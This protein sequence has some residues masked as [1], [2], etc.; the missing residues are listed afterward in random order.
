MR[1]KLYWVL[2]FCLG[3]SFLSFCQD[4]S[5]LVLTEKIIEDEVNSSLELMQKG[6]L[7]SYKKGVDNVDQLEHAVEIAKNTKLKLI[8]YKSKSFLLF[9]NYDYETALSYIN[10]SIKILKNYPDNR[11]LGLNY[12]LLGVI[13]NTQELLK[14]RDNYFLKAER[15]LSKYESFEENID[16]NFNLAY[17]YKEYEDWNK[18]I[19]YSNQALSFIKLAEQT[20]S[21]SRY[22]NLFLAESYLKLNDLNRVKF[23]LDRVEKDPSFLPDQL[24]LMASYFKIKGYLFE[25]TNDFKNATAS[26]NISSD[27]YQKLSLS[28]SKE[29][30]ETLK[31]NHNLQ[32]KEKENYSIKKEIEY[33]EASA[34]YKNFIL[35]LSFFIILILFTLVFYQ[36][37]TSKFKTSTNL[38]LAKNNED[39]NEKNNEIKKVLEVKNK[40]LDTVT[41]ELRTPLNT[42]KGVSYLLENNIDTAKNEEYFKALS[43]SSNYL[44]NLVNNIIEYNLL[45]NND[46]ANL[47]NQPTNIFELVNDTITTFKIKEGNNND[48]SCNIDEYIP[49]MLLIDSMKLTQVLINLLKNSEKFTS[50]GSII[51]KITMKKISF[52][53]CELLFEIIDNGIGISKENKEIIEEPFIKDENKINSIENSNGLGLSIVKRTLNIFNSK[54]NIESEINKGTR[55]FFTIIFDNITENLIEKGVSL[56]KNITTPNIKILLVEDNKVNQVITKKI[57]NKIGFECDVANDGLEAV[58]KNLKN[59][60][61]LVLMDIMMPVMDGF[62]ASKEISK[63][64]PNTP[65]VALTAISGELNN[66]KFIESNILEVLNKPVDVDVLTKTIYKYI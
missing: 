60:Y 31:L 47:N 53:N 40:F 17:I 19:Y 38:L 7:D 11:L 63:N 37:R 56:S 5:K 35:I 66:K 48:F 24:L 42:I 45:E 14:E 18:V 9:K 29:I 3:F 12:E 1:L 39:L 15:L 62:Q 52:S 8:F 55:I 20:Q 21:R 23:Y 25:K 34:N 44:I 30:K 13:Y 10:K 54:L 27:F 64:T 49:K 43:F 50:S 16:I 36:Y 61:S 58:H 4:Y 51:L 26:F 57:L 46:I 41:H 22:L 59:E 6:D 33:T 32:L 2:I 28:R 65:I